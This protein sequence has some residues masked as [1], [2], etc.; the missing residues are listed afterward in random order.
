CG[1][2]PRGRKAPK[3]PLQ[4]L[5]LAHADNGIEIAGYADIGDVSRAAGQDAKIRRW[6]MGVR[7]D[8]HARSAIA[9]ITHCLLF[10]RGLAVEIDNDD[11]GAAAERTRGKLAL[12]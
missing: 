5:L 11:I 6:H 1:R 9:K 7:A 12:D 3:E 4:R 10:A 2:A 8:H